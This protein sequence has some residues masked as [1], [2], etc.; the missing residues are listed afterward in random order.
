MHR[1]KLSSGTKVSW[2]FG[3]K[4]TKNFEHLLQEAKSRGGGGGG[5]GVG[6]MQE[7]KRINRPRSEQIRGA[8]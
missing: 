8:A 6:R 7:V 1:L 3:T 5:G 4:S 2:E